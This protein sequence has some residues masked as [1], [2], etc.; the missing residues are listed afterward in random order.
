MSIWSGYYPTKP[1]GT[2]PSRTYTLDPT[3]HYLQQLYQGDMPHRCL[4]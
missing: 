1:N 2:K 3:T 4:L